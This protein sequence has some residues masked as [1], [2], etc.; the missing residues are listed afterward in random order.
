M[1]AKDTFDKLDISESNKGTFILACDI[2]FFGIQSL[3]RI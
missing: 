1:V 3:V 2:F